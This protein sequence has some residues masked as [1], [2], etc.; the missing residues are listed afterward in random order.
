VA[1]CTVVGDS[2]TIL[3]TR[4]RVMPPTVPAAAPRV[5][6]RTVQ[7]AL[8][9]PSRTST[10]I[11]STRLMNGAGTVALPA[12]SQPELPPAARLVWFDVLKFLQGVEAFGGAR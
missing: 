5:S 7:L 11:P 2:G 9:A 3:A 1:A 12:G 6:V 10:S 8:P 4:S